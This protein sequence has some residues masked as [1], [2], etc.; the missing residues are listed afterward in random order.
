VTVQEF[1]ARLERVS[2]THIGW[3]ARC[4]AHEDSRPSLSVGATD[5]GRILLR[6]F[7]GCELGAIVGALRLEVKDL[8]ADAPAAVEVQ[9][10]GGVLPAP[11]V[12]AVA[13][14]LRQIRALP[15][16]EVEQ[17]FGASLLSEKKLA[18]VICEDQGGWHAERPTDRGVEVERR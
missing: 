7:A 9:R 16:A 15:D 11:Q 13:S 10:G 12:P 6:C 17:L 8:F 2:K 1:L 3:M 5:E 14:W 18:Q 4:P